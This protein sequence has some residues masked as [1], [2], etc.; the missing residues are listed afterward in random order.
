MAESYFALFELLK[1]EFELW[2]YHIALLVK[3]LFGSD[4]SV[5]IVLFTD[6]AKH[7]FFTLLFQTLLLLILKFQLHKSLLKGATQ[8]LARR[9]ELFFYFFTAAIELVKLLKE[10]PEGILQLLL[11]SL[12]FLFKLNLVAY[13]NEKLKQIVLELLGHAF[14]VLEVQS[15]LLFIGQLFAALFLFRN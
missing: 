6:E 15:V 9:V 11:Y 10:V 4:K 8:L 5:H 12:P 13:F 7:S 14:V 1:L 2:E 3:N